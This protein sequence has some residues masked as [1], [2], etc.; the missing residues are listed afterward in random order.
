MAATAAMPRNASLEHAV[1]QDD[2]DDV[3]A[4]LCLPG[5]SLQD[6]N[7]HGSTIIHFASSLGCEASLRILLNEPGAG[8]LVNRPNS[9]P[10]GFTALM[11]AARDGRVGA[12][13][14]LLG[15]NADPSLK[16]ENG[17]TAI[18]F[19]KSKG[20]ADCEALLRQASKPPVQE[21]PASFTTSRD[22]LVE[23][24]EGNTLARHNGSR[25]VEGAALCTL[26]CMRSGVYQATFQLVGDGVTAAVGVC[27][28]AHDVNGK[29]WC[30]HYL[31]TGWSYSAS[32]G[33]MKHHN[34][35]HRLAGQ[36]ATKPSRPGSMIE[37]ELDATQST[38][39]VRVDGGDR[40]LMASSVSCTNGL[41]WFAFLYNATT[42]VR[43]VSARQ[44]HDSEAEAE[45][46][47]EPE[48]QGVPEGLPLMP[49]VPPSPV[50][51]RTFASSNFRKVYAKAKPPT[52]LVKLGSVLGRMLQGHCNAHGIPFDGDEGEEFLD[53]L[54][55]D[56]QE[57]DS[58]TDAVQRMWTSF[59]TL[60]GREFCSI[61]NEVARD[62]H[63]DLITPA[64]ALTRAITRLCVTPDGQQ[65]QPP[66]PP[67]FVCYRGGGFDDQYRQFFVAGR[68][69]R[70]P[71]FLPTSFLESTAD[72]FI[73][74]STM[75]SKV[76]WLVRIDEHK[77]CR[78]VNLVT[79]RV[80]GLPD[81]QEYLF[82]PYSVF[83][84]IS[85][86]WRVGTTD[87]PHLIELLAAPDNKGP[88]EE[89]PLAP[90]S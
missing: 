46:A 84:V 17:W 52:N 5:V 53:Q 67:G 57:Q 3:R 24:H 71:A 44:L 69:F 15:R 50:S 79:K 6:V 90:W 77:K 29:H 27:D 42:A 14:L 56:M 8:A 62:D 48:L 66:F 88:S 63:P 18:E 65:P 1:R 23:L 59:R 54:Q 49:P 2:A 31:S 51:G 39:H 83:T 76:K 11:L 61:L 16:D 55:E 89:L 10:W 4:A 41:V 34:A 72:S 60:R 7:E 73:A 86:T 25:A 40:I 36:V 75:P 78:H 33:C 21:L 58:L 38:L 80:P 19:A 85:V 74:R 45:A 37:L 26:H 28:S 20:R 12:V 30:P 43:L 35:R 47:P 13:R 81:E 32:E 22:R 87:T 70:Q 68:V 9:P 64:A 82:A